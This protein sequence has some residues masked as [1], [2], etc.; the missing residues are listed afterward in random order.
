MRFEDLARGPCG[1]L[2]K[3]P[4][5]KGG[6]NAFSN[7]PA[8]IAQWQAKFPGA[9]W[10]LRCGGHFDVLDVDGIEGLKW[11]RDHERELPATR[12]QIT[13]RGRH[14][15]FLAD[16]QVRPSVGKIAEGIDVR[17]VGSYVI[18]W[19]REGLPVTDQPIAPWPK[20][21]AALAKAV[22]CSLRAVDEMVPAIVP[23]QRKHPSPTINLCRRT[24]QI[25]RVVEYAKPGT[26]NDRLYWAACRFGEIMAEGRLKRGVA[27][28]LLKSAAQICGLERDDGERA[29]VATILSG[30]RRGFAVWKS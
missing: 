28:Q 14:Y 30:L 19:W 15:Y 5:I 25:L 23:A 4:L 2:T 22:G 26:R 9:V 8:L 11:L 27:A 7:D 16:A 21:L 10:G 3:A 12:V 13:P 18:A 1:R 24:D 6:H 20:W 29:V 17:A